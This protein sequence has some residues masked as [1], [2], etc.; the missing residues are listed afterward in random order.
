MAERYY[1][2]RQG[3]LDKQG[4]PDSHLQ[5]RLRI[6]KIL[7][8]L[9][10]E[11]LGFAS[12][13][14]KWTYPLLRIY[15]PIFKFEYKK[16][17]DIVAVK[18][19]ANGILY[20]LIVE[21]DDLDLHGKKKQQNRDNKAKDIAELLFGNIFFERILKSY[22]NDPAITDYEIIKELGLD[23]LIKYKNII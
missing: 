19:L 14:Y 9:G 2:S 12:E 10:F 11:V 3:N 21:V 5:A 16:K 13:Q 22:V 1:N 15:F 6:K 23:F 18:K 4:E 8:R 7:E 17:F 20:R